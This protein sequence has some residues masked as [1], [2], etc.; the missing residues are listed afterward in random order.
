MQYRSDNL[1]IRKGEMIIDRKHYVDSAHTSASRRVELTSVPG[2]RTS[3][4]NVFERS[5]LL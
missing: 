5:G 3:K 1:K 4:N 2:W